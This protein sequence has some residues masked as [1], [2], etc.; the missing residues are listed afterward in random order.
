MKI[1]ILFL[2]ILALNLF[3]SELKAQEIRIH[4]G[5]GFR[6]T[7]LYWQEYH[8][9]NDF[10]LNL[11]IQVGPTFIFSFDELNLFKIGALLNQKGHRVVGPKYRDELDGY[12][13]RFDL[14]YLDIPVLYIRNFR[15]NNQMFFAEIGPYAGIGLK[16][17]LK[18]EYYL[19]GKPDYKEYI[20]LGK[21]NIDY[22]KTMDYGVV[23]GVG[24]KIKSLQMGISFSH[25]LRNISKWEI[26]NIKNRVFMINASYPVFSG[27]K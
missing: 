12:D 25:G 13:D 4:S 6:S 3:Q 20:L 23:L 18:M 8:K 24:T 10:I 2:F 21:N 7:S 11:G 14:F 9:S 22:I 16:G 27:S 15:I 1:K 17:K 19:N 26:E 5:I